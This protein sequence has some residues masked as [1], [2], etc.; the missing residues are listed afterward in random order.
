VESVLDRFDMAQANPVDTPL[1]VQHSLTAPPSPSLTG[2]AVPSASPSTHP[3]PEL[4]G[5]LM[6][7]MM[8]T[9]PDLA[10]PV[11]VLSRFVGPG[12]HSEEHWL[13][14]RR[15][16]RYLRGTSDLV[17]TLGGTSPPQLEGYSDSSWADD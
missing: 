14:A 4:V 10:Y 11:S 9:R 17:L 13:A 7:A 5:S 16:L 3:Y 1:P 12:R 15:V 2:P 8:C 6:Y